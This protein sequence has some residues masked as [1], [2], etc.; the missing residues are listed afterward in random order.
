[1][2][3]LV[4]EHASRQNAAR[5][6]ERQL[7]AVGLPAAS[8]HNLVE[9]LSGG[10]QQR[11]ALARALVSLPALLVLDDPTSELDPASAQTVVEVLA[12]AAARGACCLVSSDDPVLLDACDTQISLRTS[13]APHRPRRARA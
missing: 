3:L 1:M 5:R 8:W 9:Q 11:V 10:Q 6:A 7:E 4:G 2:L 12:A 13:A